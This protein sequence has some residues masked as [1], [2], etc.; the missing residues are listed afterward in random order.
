MEG[1]IKLHRKFNEWEWYNIS[2]MVH[3]FIHLLIN[4]NSKD[5]EWRGVILK[6]GQILTGLHSLHESTKISI[7][8]I[9]TCLKRLEKTS[10]IN[11]QVTNKYSI[12]TICK[13]EDYQS[14][15]ITTNK[16]PNK[17]LTSNQQSTNNKQEEEEYKNEKNSNIAVK[18]ITSERIKIFY[19]SLVPFLERHGKE[20][21]KKFYDYWTEPNKSGTK[22]RFELEKTWELSRRLNTWE[23]REK[24]PAKVI[25]ENLPI[26][27]QW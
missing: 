16:Q 21:I 12:I 9:R 3:L 19:D 7:Q 1:W 11:I 22:M 17:Q 18:K 6:R 2:E 23:S 14:E 15:K 24:I 8:T 20:R 26:R 4:A 27:T 10:E 5:G 25:E 13:Y